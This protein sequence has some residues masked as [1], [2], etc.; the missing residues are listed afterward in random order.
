[1]R[2]LHVLSQRPDSTGS[3]I[4]IR[5]MI[6]E[7]IKK[8]HKNYLLAGLPKGEDLT[9]FELAPKCSS[10]VYFQGQDLS[11]P[12]VGMSDVMPYPSK[13]FCDLSS[14]ELEAY[15]KCF[16]AKLEKMVQS[17]EPDIIHTHHLWLV[18]ALVRELFRHLPQV[19]TC[20]GSDL[21]QFQNCAHLQ[22]RVLGPC[23]KI[24][25]VLA[26]SRAQKDDIVRFYQIEE[27]KIHVVGAGYN[28]DLFCPE[29][30][31]T[32][33]PVHL[34]YAGKL[35]RAKGVPWLLRALLR[36]LDEGEEFVLHLVGGGS[37]TEKETC[38]KLAEK[39]GPR[40]RVYGLISQQELARVLK[41]GHIFILPSFFEG[42]PLVLLEAL[43]CGCRLVATTLPGV[44]EVL[45]RNGKVSD[46]I[47]LVPLPRLQQVDV[48]V[49]EDEEKFIHN[50]VQCLKKQIRGAQREPQLDL[51]KVE[52][53]L[54]F[55]SWSVV[56]ARVEKV[57]DLVLKL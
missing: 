48:P 8:G 39:F 57:Y 33:P 6:R 38:L 53:L 7:A 9:D 46:Y 11:F 3:G 29:I 14:D 17:F 31:P 50:L 20:H 34:V 30:K 19:T 1:M 43:A 54:K 32:P 35:S 27:R 42:L 4:Y 47:S 26:L 49:Q 2:I 22:E 36:L 45:C 52:D 25:A 16:A 18:S 21:R 24:D 37:G 40:C 13:R 5:A 56:F 55:Y 10:F 15:E 41:Q 28:D 23:Q 51:T 44:L 12:I